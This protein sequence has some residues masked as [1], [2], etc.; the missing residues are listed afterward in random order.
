MKK[1]HVKYKNMRDGAKLRRLEGEELLVKK[2]KKKK[3]MK[4]EQKQGQ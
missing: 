4:K 2:D 1:D 3:Y